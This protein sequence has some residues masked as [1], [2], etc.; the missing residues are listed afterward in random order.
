MQPTK[1]KYAAALGRMSGRKQ[2]AEKGVDYFR[3]LGKKSGEARKKKAEQSQRQE[4]A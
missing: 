4:Q 3:N 2:L 1:N